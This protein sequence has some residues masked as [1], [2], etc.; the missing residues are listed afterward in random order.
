M[1]RRLAATAALACACAIASA[2]PPLPPRNAL[3][4]FTSLHAFAGVDG[5]KPDAALSTPPQNRQELS[6][7]AIASS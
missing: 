5:A 1:I 4:D 7:Q 3:T 6:R 2:A